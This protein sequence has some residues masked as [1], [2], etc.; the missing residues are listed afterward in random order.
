[1]SFPLSCYR[2]DKRHKD[3][4][5]HL[6]DRIPARNMLDTQRPGTLKPKTNAMCRH[7]NTAPVTCLLLGRRMNQNDEM[8]SD[9][10]WNSF[11][12]AEKESI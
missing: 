9:Y 4:D 2:H 11:N 6:S 7:C 5:L 12:R 1:M 3:E 8:T 10:K